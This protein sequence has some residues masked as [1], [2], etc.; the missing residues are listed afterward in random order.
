MKHCECEILRVITGSIIRQMLSGGAEPDIFW[1]AEDKTDWAH[2][3]PVTPGQ[4]IQWI[5]N[6]EELTKDMIARKII[7]ER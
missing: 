5:K 4:D 7:P 1:T 3:F 2:A 6:F